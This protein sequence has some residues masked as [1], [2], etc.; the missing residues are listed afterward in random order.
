MAKLTLRVGDAIVVHAPD[1]GIK[2]LPMAKIIAITDEPGKTVGVEFGDPVGRHS[3]DGAGKTGYCLWVAPE[4]I[5][6]PKEA[7]ELKKVE[8]LTKSV[9]S[10]N[11]NMVLEVDGG[12]KAVRSA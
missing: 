5:L 12:R 4:H 9:A 10:V 3:C 7:E 6:L 11:K 2:S 1:H 8:S